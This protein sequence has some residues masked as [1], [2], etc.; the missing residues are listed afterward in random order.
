VALIFLLF[1]VF[2]IS[3]Y[4]I[5]SAS[6]ASGE[7]IQATDNNK[8]QYYGCENYIRTFHCDPLH[9]KFRAYSYQGSSIS[10]YELVNSK[11]S[12]VKGK[13]GD[14]LQLL[15]P[16]REAVHVPSISKFTFK[17]FS[18]SFWIKSVPQPEPVGHV[19]SYTNSLLSAGWFFDMRQGNGTNQFI[20]FAITDTSKKLFPSPD[21][22]I[23]LDTFH[24]IVGT[25]NGS[26][27]RIFKDG[28]LIGEA[29]YQG[30][31]SGS[32]GIPLTIGSG[33]YC[34]S[35]NRWSGIIDD[36]RIYD[37]ALTADQVK[38]LLDRP[39]DS[40]IKGIIAHWT[41]DRQFNDI[42]GN[43]HNGRESTLLA[44]MVFAHDGRLF[45]SEKNT[46]LIR[47]I[48][49]GRILEPPFA[50]ISDYYVNWEQG[51]LGL[52]IDPNFEQN[53]YLYLYYTA[54]NPIT[55]DPYN[56]V[57][58]FT[59]ANNIGKDV[60]ILVDNIPAS[61]GYHA[62]G[63]L[64]F[65][66]DDKLYFTVGD[67][68][69]HPFAEDPSVVIGKILRINRDGT[70][71]QDNP[72]PNSPVYTVG[73]RN[74]YGLAFD[75]Y[76]NGLVTENGD[77]YY[78]EINLIQ[79][80]GN[81][82]FP[83]YQ[84]PNMS[85]ELANTTTIKPLRTYWDTVAPTQMFYY[86]GD[87]I[88]L[89]KD[90]FVLGTYQGD[91]YA[92]R[93]DRNTKEIVEENRLDLENYPFKPVV[94]IT[95]SPD[96][97]VY[98]GAYSIYK[99]NSSDISPKSQYLFPIEINTSKTSNIGGVKFTRFINNTLQN[100]MTI[101]LQNDGNNNGSE[102]QSQFP[103]SLAL[104]IPKGLFNKVTTVVNTESGKQMRFLAHNTTNLEDN[105]I[106]IQIPFASHL[107]LAI[108]G[109]AP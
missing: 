108:I 79:K 51:L 30:T 36:L 20:R 50:T 64:A 47:I 65:G 95:E 22:P 26:L 103:P 31:Y 48:K 66:P 6:E 37:K 92:L 88:P 8:I 60:K 25:F 3:S 27:I 97:D 101:D 23:E 62:G 17:D 102:I 89:L 70:I 52:T 61:R 87:K 99:L 72:F 86:E 104:K 109:P 96:G 80:G 84:P 7:V 40:G 13:Y 18:V 10:I 15:G 85:P 78:D 106:S 73:H 38:Q 45:F 1:S 57:V 39:F 42:S 16:Y 2:F 24:Q 46:G 44:S 83:I 81:Y 43:N 9:N 56:K 34:A 68:T 76:G 14:A 54:V 77:Y 33:A 71:P 19:V 100:M 94:G 82:G 5:D 49:D 58:R 98:F 93:I 59:E 28:Q 75:K 67:A 29:N 74:M 90:K 4:V 55:K 32:P 107:E 35:C 21:V 69:E 63:A 91:M 12:F 105:S 41:F 53:H 11:P